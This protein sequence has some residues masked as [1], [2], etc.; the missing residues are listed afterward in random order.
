MYRVTH[1]GENFL[2]TQFRQ[3][4]QLVGHNR[5]YLL[6]RQCD[7]SPET[8]EGDPSQMDVFTDEMGYPVRESLR[9]AVCIEAFY[10]SGR[11]QKILH[12]I[13]EGEVSGETGE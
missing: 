3:F 12:R 1:L 8:L 6:P 10:F 9:F 5:S 7:G 4:R 13:S 2:L 11:P